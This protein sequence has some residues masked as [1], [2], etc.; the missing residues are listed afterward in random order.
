MAVGTAVFGTGSVA[1][2][3]I[4]RA[5]SGSEG[6][7]AADTDTTGATYYP[8][9]PR[10]VLDS[11]DGTGGL[12][13]PFHSHVARSVQVV[14]AA[15]GVP[16]GASAVTGNLTVTG[17][18]S[19]GYLYVGPDAINDPASST[20]NFPASDD[21]ANSVTVA[22]SAAGSLSIT[23]AAPSLG[24]T[25]HVIFD[26]TGYF[27]PPD[28]TG[29]TYYPLT[30]R[31]VLDSRDGTGGLAGPFHS[32][33]ARSVQVVGAAS[34]VP[35]GASAVTGN[36]TVT[37][38]TSS[39]YLYV[40]PDAINDPASST[41]NFPASDD[42]ANSVTVALSAAGSLSITY[43][44]PSLGPTA[45]VIFDL[46]G[47]FRPP[48]TT[49]ATYY[50]LT[51]RR[52]L[53]SR[54]GTGGLAG[55]FHS[56]VARSVQVVG[57]ASGVPAGASAVTGNLTVTGQTSSGYLYV[58]PDAIN[59]PASSTLNFPA[60]DDRA[61]SV[62]VA[63]SAAGS[64][65]ITYAAPSLGPTA[66][67]IFDLTGYFVGPLYFPTNWTFDEY[68]ARA[69]RYQDPDYTA[70]TAAATESML[71][72]ITYA[73]SSAGLVWQ[74]TISYDVQE[75]IL[76]YER[77]HMT[78]LSTSAGTDPHGWR[79]ALNYYGWGSM[80]AGVYR[81]SAYSSF[82]AA[83]RA[84]VS[85]LAVYRKPVGILALAGGHA[86][87]ITGYQVSG[88]DP[89]SGS[90]A[91]TVIG[92]NLTDPYQSSGHRDTWVTRSQ[93]QSGTTWLRFSPY[94]ETD[95]PYRDPIDGQVGYD[96][97]YGKWVILDPVR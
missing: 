36:L 38:Q 76:A 47:Y 9:T 32:H 75:S 12:A 45:H 34:G 87:F 28:T 26:L 4:P 10:R 68:D 46:T 65:S 55:P 80:S 7:R 66:H 16:A 69:E 48:D 25:A 5:T 73:A 40:G 1:G 49:G 2:A 11:R 97:W 27:R 86:Q 43:A 37:G 85:A 67:V 14:G 52:V 22:L 53:D 95:S 41:L 18:T 90:M 44:A 56:H 6:G 19:S 71:N 79:N 15:S 20:L 17:Q 21:R 61:N 31:R 92:V 39:G 77:N 30:P 57:A 59:D 89:A 50:P 82:D 13:G 70:C 35:A 24:P 88:D 94:L 33:V 29:A 63:L 84:A 42:R 60:S 81:D 51:P 93:W 64:L 62:T 83:A 74:P 23:Y 8:L 3:A 91:F 96:E 54:D 72:T 78:M 58:G